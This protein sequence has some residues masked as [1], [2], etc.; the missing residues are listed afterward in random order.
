MPI[1]DFHLFFFFKSFL[2]I[3]FFK[4]LK[5]SIACKQTN[6]VKM[7][8]RNCFGFPMTFAYILIVHCISFDHM[9]SNI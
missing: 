5:D 3:Q 2:P 8:P 4:I 9:C 1:I 7:S 6:H